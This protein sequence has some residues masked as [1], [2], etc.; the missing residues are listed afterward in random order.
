MVKKK[1]LIKLL[2]NGRRKKK[3]YV[4]EIY[5]CSLSI[6]NSKITLKP[7]F[8]D[9]YEVNEEKVQQFVFCKLDAGLK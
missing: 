1:Q 8:G 5:I 7:Y 4:K 2:K 9:L 6:T 3:K